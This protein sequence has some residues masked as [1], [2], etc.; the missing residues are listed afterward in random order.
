MTATDTIETGFDSKT[1]K[2]VKTGSP[3]EFMYNICLIQGDIYN[4]INGLESIIRWEHHELDICIS[5]FNGSNSSAA[6]PTTT[7]STLSHNI[8]PINS[9]KWR[10]RST[11]RQIFWVSL[12]NN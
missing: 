2:Q 3:M 7:T 8:N 5:V 6:M 11:A 4:L 12:L 10:F 1:L 9:K